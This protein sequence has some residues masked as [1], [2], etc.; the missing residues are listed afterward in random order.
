[1]TCVRIVFAAMTAKT[2]PASFLASVKA[3]SRAGF[4]GRGPASQSRSQRA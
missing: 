2:V 1:M 3:A 4:R